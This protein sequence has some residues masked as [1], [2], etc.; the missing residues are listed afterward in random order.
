M[1]TIFVHGAGRGGAA[2]WS[3]QRDAPGFAGAVWLDW[4]EQV[5]TPGPLAADFVDSQLEA[6][7]ARA[8]TSLD[9]VAHSGGALAALLAAQRSPGRVRSLVLLEPACFALARGRAAV[10]EHV[11]AMAPALARA[12]DPGVDDVEYARRFFAALGAPAPP[13]ETPEHLLALRRLRTVPAPW[14]V[15]LDPTV[16]EQTPTLVITGGWL[17]LYE[18]TAQALAELSA[19]HEV[20]TGHGH[21]PQD[22]PDANALIRAFQAAP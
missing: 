15:D 13:A 2:A 1:V 6:I 10:E 16:V 5:T 17:P 22:H 20:L 11:S 14:A 3:A 19:R 21:R 12:G 4:R 18:E 9:V 7:L 8:W